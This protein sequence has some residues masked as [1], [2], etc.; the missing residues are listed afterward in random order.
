[1][2]VRDGVVVDGTFEAAEWT[3]GTELRGAIA[4]QTPEC[5]PLF[6]VDLGD[7]SRLVAMGGTSPDTSLAF[8]PD[9]TRLAVGSYRGEVLVLDAWTGAIQARTRLAE[10][11]VKQVAWS[12]DGA[13]LY[14][15]EQSPDAYVHAM[16][17]TTLEPRWS[18]RLADHVGSSPAPDGEDIYGVYTLPAAYELVV[19]PDGSLL[20]GANHGWNDPDGTRRNQA[21]LLRVDPNGSVAATWPTIG[22]AEVTFNTLRADPE[23]GLAIV[24]VG[25]SAA[26]DPPLGLPVGGVQVVTLADLSPVASFVPPPLAPHF[27]QTFV[28]EAI[29]VD[30]GA[31]VGIVGLSDGRLFGFPLRGDAAPWLIEVSTPVMAGSVPISASIGHGWMHDGQVL[32]MTSGTN[33]PYGSASPEARPSSPHPKANAV[34]AY[35][36]EDQALRWTWTGAPNLNGLV[37]IGDVAI[38]GTRGRS[39]DARQDQYGALPF[40]LATG[41]KLAHCGTEG[42]TFFRPTGTADG[43][44]AVAEHPFGKGDGSLGGAYRVTVLR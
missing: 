22:A 30:A 15:G 26:G 37:H 41:R 29:D 44:I 16:D 2:F 13:T 19:L 10:T 6:S 31:D 25:R 36:L 33:I 20:V 35:G 27:T 32:V 8:S 42:P 14:T 3:P 28:W 43:R 34:F 11:M 40:D 12:P 23:G 38:A 18:L 5:V 24:A 21:R 17:P 39:S 1:M 4:P 9:G 7:V